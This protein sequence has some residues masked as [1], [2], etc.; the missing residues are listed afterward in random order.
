[1]PSTPANLNRTGSFS[2]P[3]VSILRKTGTLHPYDAEALAGWRPHHHPT[4]RPAHDLGTHLLQACH[5]GGNVVG[6]DVYV[7]ATLVVHPLDFH[8]RLVRR[9]L[10][11]SVIAA[12]VRMFGVNNAAERFAPEARGLLHVGGLAIDQHGA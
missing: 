11:H 8:D 10:Q 12:A 2:I 4:P 7:N 6:L 5:F 3:A 1:M 9:G